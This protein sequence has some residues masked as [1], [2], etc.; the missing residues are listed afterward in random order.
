MKN[1]RSYEQFLIESTP[2]YAYDGN[3]LKLGD[4]VT[5]LDGYSGMIVSKEVSN[6]K[7]VFRD[8]KG[9][10]HVCE[11]EFLVIHEYVNEAL[12]WWEVTKGV[13]ASD[14]IKAKGIPGGGISLG[15]SVY[16]TWRK[17][18]SLK[19]TELKTSAKYDEYRKMAD[20]LAD[21][22]NADDEIK[23]KITELSKYPSMISIMPVGKRKNEAIRRSLI[24]RS[25][26]IKEISKHIESKLE[27]DEI[28][29]IREINKILKDAPLL[30]EESG[31]VQNPLTQTAEITRDPQ[32]VNAKNTSLNTDPKRT[33]GTGTYTSTWHDV[34][35][36]VKGSWNSTDSASGGT[37]P[38]Y[39]G[40]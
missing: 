4:Y 27:S 36:D 24:E 12:Q 14:M 7:I 10:M 5:S 26:L 25:R 11:S 18:I 6:G 22:L 34:R 33:L 29:Y 40:N 37:V 15:G 3:Q 17:G 1:L 32:N 19:I 13:L 2:N 31:D 38:V 28:D 16:E 39:A 35:P 8:N 23:S 20:R 21:K 9:V 30:A